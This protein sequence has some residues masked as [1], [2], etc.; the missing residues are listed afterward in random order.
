MSPFSTLERRERP[1]GTRFHVC[2]APLRRCAVGGRLEGCFL[3]RRGRRD[4]QMALIVCPDCGR[5]VS[6][7]APAC[8]GCGRPMQSQPAP[9]AVRQVR[10]TNTIMWLKIG[11]ALA[12]FGGFVGCG[13]SLSQHRPFSGILAVVCVLGFVAFTAGRFMQRT[14]QRPCGVGALA[15][16][17]SR[18]LATY[19]LP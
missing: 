2:L 3:S 18:T 14:P 4:G 12:A 8:P 15:G 13:V 17:S 6:D 11:G 16:F 7:A 9:T 10:A 19:D 5:Q 1:R